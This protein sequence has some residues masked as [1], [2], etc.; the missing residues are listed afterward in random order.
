MSSQKG[1]EGR[2]GSR[3]DRD[4]SLGIAVLFMCQRLPAVTCCIFLWHGQAR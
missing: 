4:Q 2:R 1:K 3:S